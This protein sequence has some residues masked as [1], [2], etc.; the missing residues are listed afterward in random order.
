M[1]Q[2]HQLLQE[3]WRLGYSQPNG[4]TIPA[5]SHNAAT[6]IRFA[7]YNATRRFRSGD[8][9]PDE[10]LKLALANCQITITADNNVLIGKKV[11]GCAADAIL[12]ALG[13]PAKSVEDYEGEASLARIMDKIQDLQATPTP[14]PLTEAKA[15]ANAYGARG[16]T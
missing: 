13:R 3:A 10:S 1:S 4:F 5:A 9:I 6:R 11:A 16:I 14:E 12:T 7:L 2:E 8:S 15:K